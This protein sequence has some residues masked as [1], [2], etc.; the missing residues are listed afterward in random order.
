MGSSR[1]APGIT[2]VRIF[3]ACMT[4]LLLGTAG[5]SRQ[6]PQAASAPPEVSVAPALS[7]QITEFDEWMLRDWWRHLKSRYGR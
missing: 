2:P 1:R 3:F 5:C 6:A 4:G 7:R